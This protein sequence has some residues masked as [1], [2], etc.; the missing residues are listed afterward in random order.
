MISLHRLQLG[1]EEPEASRIIGIINANLPP[2]SQTDNTI[3]GFE[4]CSII[5][6]PARRGRNPQT[7]K[8]IKIAAKNVIKVKADFAASK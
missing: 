2:T 6:R 4:A 5:K 7:G 1:M 3:S 8:E